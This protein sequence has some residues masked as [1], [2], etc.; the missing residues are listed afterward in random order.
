MEKHE[1]ERAEL[2]E[3]VAQAELL[4]L[5]VAHRIADRLRWEQALTF[6]R[7]KSMDS[8]V[9]NCLRVMRS[10]LTF[11]SVRQLDPDAARI[12]VSGSLK[13]VILD[14]IETVSLEVAKGFNAGMARGEG[15]RL[16]LRGLKSVSP[17]VASQLKKCAITVGDAKKLVDAAPLPLTDRAFKTVGFV[18]ACFLGLLAF[19]K[20]CESGPPF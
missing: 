20:G 8:H 7:L 18:I 13:E 10:S 16:F 6:S 5:K 19:A 4:D 1:R 11:P 14:G 17:S 9:A 3:V 15:T 12:L 2:K